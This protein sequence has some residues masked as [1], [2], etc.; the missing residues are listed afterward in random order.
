MLSPKGSQTPVILRR[1]RNFKN[2]SLQNSPIIVH[3]PSPTNYSGAGIKS[4]DGDYNELNGQ[5]QDLE[6]GLELRLDLR[7]EDIET[8]EELGAGNGG[9]VCKVLHKPTKTIMAKKTIYP[10]SLL[11]SP[12]LINQIIVKTPADQPPQAATPQAS[13]DSS[14]TSRPSRSVSTNVLN[15]AP[16]KPP[17]PSSHTDVEPTKYTN[18]DIPAATQFV[19]VQ[20]AKHK[21]DPKL[22]VRRQIMREMQYMHDCDSKHIVSFYGAFMNDGDISMCMEYMDI[23]SLDR[24]Y[25]KHGP[26]RQDVL[27]KIAYA[28]L[29][30][31]IYLYDC[32]RIIHRDVKPSNVLVNSIGQIKIC[33]FGVSGPLID[34]IADT[35]VG[36][37][38]YMSPERILGSPYSVKSD[39]WSFGMTLLELAIGRFPLVSEDGTSP[40]VFEL[41]QRIVN[42]PVPTLP[43]NMGYS[44][45]LKDFINVC[46]LKDM[47]SRPTPADLMVSS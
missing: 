34:S 47:E 3:P 40:A 14:S 22:M 19:R 5:L 25:K 31:L 18:S 20:H 43:S 39:V 36:T 9:T 26:I 30:G 8:L 32:H 7:A 6:I 23:G 46:L 44:P 10:Q 33:D 12:A 21:V 16:Q 17:T 2:L 28:V 4:T 41:L 37:S 27:R 29:D 35:F 15:K 1:K 11:D 42:E 45:E 13:A 24:V 38:Y